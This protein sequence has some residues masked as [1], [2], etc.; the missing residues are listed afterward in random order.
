[1]SK[2]GQEERILKVVFYTTT[3]GNEPVREW[4]KTLP[5]NARRIIGEDIKVVQDNWPIGMPLVRNLGKK[6]W[7]IRSV[8]PNGI[9][10][11]FFVTKENHMVLLH[12]IVKKSQKAPQQDL[13]LA[14]HRMRDLEV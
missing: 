8:I 4:L 2:R 14:R 9:A 7:E 13:E 5:K 11:V 12:G 6:L 1:M 3:A 10:R